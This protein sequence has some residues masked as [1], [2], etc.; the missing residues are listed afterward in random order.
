MQGVGPALK[1]ERGGH[2]LLGQHAAVG[3]V[4]AQQLLYVLGQALRL[5][6]PAVVEEL[7]LMG[8]PRLALAREELD[9]HLRA[10]GRLRG[11]SRRSARGAR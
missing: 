8:V 7:L 2:A 1:D 11:L 10:R 9:G 4:A 3:C 6:R 5:Q